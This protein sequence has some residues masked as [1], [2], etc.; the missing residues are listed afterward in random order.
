MEST[1]SPSD[2]VA[3]KNALTGLESCLQMMVTGTNDG[4]TP[5]P[6]AAQALAF[7]KALK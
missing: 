1:L 3:Y 6:E 2:G 4:G 5:H 7:V